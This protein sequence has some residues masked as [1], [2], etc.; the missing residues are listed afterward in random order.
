MR[1]KLLAI[2]GPNFAYADN[3]AA[4]DDLSATGA[5]FVQAYRF[6]IPPRFFSIDDRGRRVPPTMIRGRA[7]QFRAS[8]ISSPGS[9]GRAISSARMKVSITTNP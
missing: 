4:A 8:Q 1:L 2:L 3:I 7:Q 5:V 9:K 6:G